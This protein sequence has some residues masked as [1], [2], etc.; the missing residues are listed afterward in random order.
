MLAWNGGVLALVGLLL[1][2]AGNALRARRTGS[3]G[4]LG[5]LFLRAEEITVAERI[6]NR[7]GIGLFAVGAMAGILA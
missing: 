2:V 1:V 6:L 7:G 4:C 3:I 5:H